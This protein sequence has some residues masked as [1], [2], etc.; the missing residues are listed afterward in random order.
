MTVSAGLNRL[1]VYIVGTLHTGGAAASPAVTY[2]TESMTKQAEWTEA[3]GAIAIYTLDEAGIVAASS[4]TF[5]IT[6]GTGFHDKIQAGASFV[7]VNQGAP[8]S[9]TD[10][11]TGLDPTIDTVVGYVI[12]CAGGIG[13]ANMTDVAQGGS[14]VVTERLQRDQD[15][16]GNSSIYG[17]ADDISVVAT[18]ANLS[19]T[20]DGTTAD[21]GSVAISLKAK[22]LGGITLVTV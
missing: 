17:I 11:D 4:T 1:L 16:G 5:G 19:Y 3:N 18:A 7:G 20:V 10:S 6:G 14:S 12:Q 9:A 15:D 13:S 21:I 22:P 8:V 2:G